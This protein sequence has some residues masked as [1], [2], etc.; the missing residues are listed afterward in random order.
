MSETT[1]IIIEGEVQTIPITEE[2]TEAI[3]RY[4]NYSV[5]LS[6]ILDGIAAGESPDSVAARVKALQHKNQ[7]SHHWIN[8]EIVKAG[9]PNNDGQGVQLSIQM[10]QWFMQDER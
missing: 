1:T 7:D 10:M 8:D 6:D 5:N 9:G 2:V 3:K 4:F